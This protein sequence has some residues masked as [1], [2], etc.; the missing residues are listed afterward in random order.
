[1]LRVMEEKEKTRLPEEGKPEL[2]FLYILECAD[3]S[4][5]TGITKDLDLRLAMHT[6]GKASRYTRSRRPVRM[7]YHE[8]CPSRTSALVRECE[9]KAYPRRRKEALVRRGLALQSAA[10]AFK[11]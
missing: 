5:Y 2:W 4:Y 6:S 3:G 8:S 1:M 10:E 11:D 7:L 9:V